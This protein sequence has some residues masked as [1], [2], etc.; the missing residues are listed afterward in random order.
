MTEDKVVGQCHRSYRHEFDQTLGGSGRLEG[1]V[2]SG[3]WGHEEL[4]MT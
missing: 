1:L 4:D 2:C 3:A